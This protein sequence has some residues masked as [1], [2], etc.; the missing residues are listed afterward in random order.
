MRSRLFYLAFSLIV[1]VGVFAYLFSYVS[2]REVLALIADADRRAVVMFVLLSLA[3]SV[4]RAWRYQILLRVAGHAPGAVAIF[5]TVLV[6]NLFADLLPAR[7]GSLVYVYIVNA[8]LRV[9]L[10]AATSSFAAALV[11]DVVALGPLLVAAGLWAGRGAGLEGA[12]LAGAGVVLGAASVL[13]LAGLP[14]V[15]RV[16]E[17]LA[18]GHE[19]HAVVGMAGQAAA[20]FRAELERLREAAV[21]GRLLVLSILVRLAKYASLY[22]FLFALLAPR[23]YGLADLPVVKVFVGIL[24]AEMA[25]SLPVSGIAGFGAYEGTWA[26]VFERFGFPGAIARL[27]SVA[28]HLFTQ[29]YGYGLGG[30]ALLLLLLPVWTAP[31]GRGER[32]GRR[33]GLAAFGG[34]LAAFV[35]AVLLLLRAAQEIPSPAAAAPEAGPAAGEGGRAWLAKRLPGRIVFDSNRA[36]TFGIHSIRPDG[37]DLRTIVDSGDYEEMYPDVSPDGRWIAYARAETVARTSPAE[38]RIVRP[39]GSGDRRVAANGTFPTFSGDG[40]TIYFERGRTRV[41]SV[42]VEGGKPR[43]LFR[44]KAYGFE[45]SQIV[46]PRVAP[47]GDAVVFTSDRNR[48]WEAWGVDLARRKPFRIAPGCEPAWLDGGSRIAWVREDGARHGTGIFS[49]DRA[50]GAK[51]EL[52]DAGPP[53]GHEYF[54]SATPDGRFLLY[55]ASPGEHSHLTA[56]YQIFV[57]DLASGRVVQVTTGRATHRWPKLL[58][59]G[60]SR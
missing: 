40:R 53:Y 57:K 29:A 26:F 22:V 56:P 1:S 45:G 39:D 47:G 42:P 44:P 49:F 9:P 17:R 19:A 2:P 34:K 59:P 5:L 52:Q 28:H 15:L 25:A 21:Y 50:S 32:P 18:T 54:P 3:S 37:S 20:A 8:R 36:G 48:G 27:T 4:L 41:F 11:L 24:A 31:A 10:P 51:G 13:V 60:P 46:K 38:I 14:T 23:G 16:G 30:A 55:G 7:V 12:V 58:P 33:E 43:L 6:R 35:V